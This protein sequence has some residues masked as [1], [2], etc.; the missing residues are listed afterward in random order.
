M[1][2]FKL[3][4]AA[5]LSLSITTFALSCDAAPPSTSE[6]TAAHSSVDADKKIAAQSSIARLH[7]ELDTTG[8]AKT[9]QVSIIPKEP[10]SGE[11]DDVALSGAPQRVRIIFDGKKLK[12]ADNSFNEPH[13]TI[14]PLPEYAAIFPKHKQA[15]F[16]KII[17]TLKKMTAAKSSAGLKNLPILPSSDGYEFLHAQEKYLNFKQGTGV[18]YISVYGNGDPPVNESDFFYTFQ[19]MTNDAK[20]Y[21]AFFW[22]V[23]ATGLPKDLP[24]TKSKDYVEKLA[25]GKFSPSLETLDKVVSSIALK[26]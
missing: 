5:F 21:V 1:T 7:V 13:L 19:G 18:S 3:L 25:R 10:Y 16:N 17:S 11:D 4:S 6:K 8:I 12:Y 26:Y 22:P 23:K 15:E 2:S 14:Y 9:T 24:L 20:Y